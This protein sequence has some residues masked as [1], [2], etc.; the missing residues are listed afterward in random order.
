MQFVYVLFTLAVLGSMIFAPAYFDHGYA[1]DTYTPRIMKQNALEELS[2][3][4]VSEKK[5]QKR[6]EKAIKSLEKSL[7][8]KQWLDDFTLSMKGKKVFDNDKKAIK[9]LTKIKS[10]D[11]SEIINLLIE[12]DRLLAQIEIDNVPT[13]TGIK[14]V[15]KQLDKAN[16]AMDKA[17]KTLDKNKFEKA[18]DNFKKAWKLIALKGLDL[19]ETD[20]GTAHFGPDGL[21]DYYVKTLY[22]G[23]PK[24]PLI[25]YYKIQNECV[26]LGPKDHPNEGGD[27]FEDAAMKIGV[28]TLDK[29]W[30]SDEIT[31]TNKWFKSGNNDD[32]KKIDLISLP[33]ISY[34]PFFDDESGDDVIQGTIAD[35]SFI[36]VSSISE[37]DGQPGWEGSIIFNALPGDYILWTIHPAGGIEGCDL[38]DGLG[39]DVIISE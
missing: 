4:D 27:T 24:K 38:L 9:E 3:L 13:D 2:S 17:Q 25:V 35:A 21:A 8:E 28:S 31:V 11:V 33:P 7:K 34:S 39:I 15:N 22:T 1:D 6:V 10:I 12:S 36:Q 26:D 30:L 29:Q 32:N 18:I 16:K 20:S 37:L 23:D 14:K 5:D 19:Y